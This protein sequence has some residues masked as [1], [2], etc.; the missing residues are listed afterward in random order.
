MAVY[1]LGVSTKHRWADGQISVSAVRIG[2]TRGWSAVDDAP[3]PNTAKQQDLPW[4]AQAE[5][6]GPALHLRKG[7]D[8]HSGGAQPSSCT[9]PELGNLL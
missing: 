5:S 1:A 4:L 9:P 3:R 6:P 8:R 7:P 2:R